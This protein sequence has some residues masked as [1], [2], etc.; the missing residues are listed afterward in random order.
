M[1]V[2]YGDWEDLGSNYGVSKELG[3]H[4]GGDI[5]VGWTWFDADDAS[6]ME[7]DDTFWVTYTVNF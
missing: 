5:A 6:M 3:N 2:W 4:F 1:N 7:D